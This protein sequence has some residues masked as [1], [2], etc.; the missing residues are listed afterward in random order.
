MRLVFV[1]YPPK[2]SEL[3]AIGAAIGHRFCPLTISLVSGY[4]LLHVRR[5]LHVIEEEGLICRENDSDESDGVERYYRFLHDRIQQAAYM[6]MSESD[7]ASLHLTIGR[8]IRDH[9]LSESVF[10]IF[11]RVHH[12]NLGSEKIVDDAEKRELAAFNY[13]AV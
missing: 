13:Q 7:Q 12:L 10:T 1:C 11:D 5:L 9:L 6:T 2:R 3:L 8:V 4:P